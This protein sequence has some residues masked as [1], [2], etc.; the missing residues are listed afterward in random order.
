MAITKPTARSFG[1]LSSKAQLARSIDALVAAG[2]FDSALRLIHRTVDQVFCEPLA[3]ASIYGS[4]LLDDYCQHIGAANW[5]NICSGT[6]PHS[7]VL[8]SKD[9]VVYVASQLYAS[10]GHTAVLADLIRLG[11]SSRNFV[12]LTGTTGITD[13]PAIRDRFASSGPVSFESAPRGTHLAK[14]DWLQR[15][16]RQLAPHT[17][18]LFNHHQDSVAVAAVQPDAGYRLRFYH[19]GDH[20]LCLGVHLTY[21]EHVDPHP[22]GFHNC[23]HG[24]G[25]IHNRYLPLVV[26]DQ[27]MQETGAKPHL[28]DGLVTCTAARRNK[29]APPY[30]VRYTDVI[31]ELLNVSRGKHIHI[32][33]LDHLTLF[34]IRRSIRKLGLPA[35]SFVYIPFVPSVWRALHV[36]GVDLYVTSFPHGGARTLIEAMG[37]GTA[38]APHVHYSSRLLSTFDMAY[39]GALFWRTP[40]EL[41]RH[42]RQLDPKRLELQRSAA[43]A[44]YEEH[45]DEGV[46]SEALANWEKP[47]PPPPLLAGYVPDEL[48][49]ALAVSSQVSCAGVLGRARCRLLKRWKASLGCSG[50]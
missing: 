10:G 47:V 30:H 17:V 13:G 4:R 29:I 50:K 40:D 12:L 46:L 15:R 22:M 37:A 7:A 48:Q 8:P 21:A 49:Q 6:A 26:K 2:R 31:P 28:C 11:P 39:E 35:H 44:R 1:R 27:G 19:H 34:R 9:V 38:V 33:R 14:L 5:R 25:L 45:H 18:W 42:V 43:R 41:Y 20:H 16:L 24:L 36:Y 23:R 32:G 3:T